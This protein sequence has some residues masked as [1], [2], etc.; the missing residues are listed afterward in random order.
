M[1]LG[2][3]VQALLWRQGGSRELAMQSSEMTEI[4]VGLTFDDVLLVPGRSEVHPNQVDV[5]TTLIR[6]RI[7]LRLPII[8][9]AMDTVTEA[10]MAIAMAQHGGLGVIHKNLSIERQVEEVDKVKRSES[11]MIVDPVTVNPDQLVQEA[12][13]IMARYKISG[14]PVVDT[15]GQLKGILTNRDLRFCTE[16]SHPISDFMTKDSLVT[17]PVGTTLEEAKA[18]LHRYRIE[19]LLVVDDEGSLKGLI[20]VKDIKKAQQFPNACKDSFGRLRVAAAI[21][22]SADLEE[23]S[24]RLIERHV[25][26]LCLDSSHAHSRGIMDAVERIKGRLPEVPLIVGNIAT[27]EAAEDLIRLGADCLKVGIG[28]GSICTTRVVTGG[29]MPQI[30]AIRSCAEVA[31]KHG[32]PLIADGGIRFSGDI[33]KAL[34]AGADAV[35][36]GSLFAGVQESPGERILYRGR[37]FKAYRGMGSLGAM[38]EAHGSSDRYFQEDEETTKLVPEG[39]EGMVPFKGPLSDQLTQLIGGV[40]AGMGLSG[41]ASIAEL[42]SNGRFIRVTAAGHHESHAHDVTITKEA[43]NYRIDR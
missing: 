3:E 26:L 42:H 11:G 6:D 16:F 2:Q 22:V 23:R 41:C 13:D 21:G 8:S 30:T 1:W 35:M 39:I 28:P 25:D 14:L 9:A 31:H 20:T 40:R 19:K 12:L 4:P 38:K 29:G 34:A 43:P 17:A 5:S 32:V 15:Q 37:T 33:T 27:A 24:T 10:S 36:I 7:D 18:L